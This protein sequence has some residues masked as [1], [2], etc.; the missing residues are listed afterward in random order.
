MPVAIST[1]MHHAG[2]PCVYPAE[3]ALRYDSVA[4]GTDFL[5]VPEH[6]NHIRRWWLTAMQHYAYAGEV[7]YPLEGLE[8][9]ERRKLVPEYMQ[10][11]TVCCYLGRSAAEPCGVCWKCAG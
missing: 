8:R 4:F 9:P 10:D 7:L 6:D 1:I 11:W 3:K 5:D 2:D